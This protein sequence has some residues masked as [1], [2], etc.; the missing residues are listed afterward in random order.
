[1]R[2]S[3]IT[4]HVILSV[5]KPNGRDHLRFVGVRRRKKVQMGGRVRTG[6]LWLSGFR[7]RPHEN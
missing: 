7:T 3:N 6:V 1:M 2:N 5:A 4:K